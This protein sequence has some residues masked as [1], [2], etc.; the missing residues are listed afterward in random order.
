M[1]VTIQYAPQRGHS[2]FLSWCID[3]AQDK[4]RSDLHMAKADVPTVTNES[5]PSL[6]DPLSPCTGV[7]PFI[8]SSSATGASPSVRVDALLAGAEQTTASSRCFHAPGFSYG[9]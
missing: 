4:R 7:V 8:T 1:S 9:S 6:S 5:I 2:P 3:K